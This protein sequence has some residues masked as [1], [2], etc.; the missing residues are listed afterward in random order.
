MCGR[1]RLSAFD[2]GNPGT[3]RRNHRNDK[4]RQTR[5]ETKCVQGSLSERS[6]AR[7]TRYSAGTRSAFLRRKVAL[8][9][10][11]TIK[12]NVRYS[13]TRLSCVIRVKSSGADLFWMPICCIARALGGSTPRNCS[14]AQK[15]TPLD[16]SAN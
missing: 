15:G 9:L 12:S 3:G 16:D 6:A 13:R 11:K 4:A 7:K 2:D 1:S 10:S 5:V 14:H 8:V